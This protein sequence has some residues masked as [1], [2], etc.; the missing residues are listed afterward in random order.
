MKLDGAHFNGQTMHVSFTDEQ[1]YVTLRMPVH[2]VERMV[3]LLLLELATVYPA[4]WTE[5]NEDAR[6][7]MRGQR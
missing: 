2:E 7:V 5:V 3:S 1:A 6:A 4:R